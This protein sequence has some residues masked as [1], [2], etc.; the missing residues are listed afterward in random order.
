LLGSREPAIVR[1]EV[2]LLTVA[3]RR[4]RP[5]DALA[6]LLDACR[7]RRTTPQRLLD[8][9]EHLRQLPRRD[10]FVRVLHDAKDGVHSF[11]ELTYLRKVERAHGLPAGSRQVRVAADGGAIYR[12]VEYE[13]YGL[14]VE[15]DGRTG[16]E[17]AGSRWR[18]MS[19]DNAAVMEAKQTLRFGYQLVSDPC[20]AATQLAAVLRARGWPGSPTPCAPTCPLHSLNSL[21]SF[22][23]QR[24]V[25]HT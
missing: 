4:S 19:R 21:H 14:I 15:L 13:D 11:L 20:T 8:E 1:L 9:L 6:L 18:D 23:R 12:D 10:L 22:A 5:D 25:Q 2:A 3:S 7:Q 16:H 17:D 24:G